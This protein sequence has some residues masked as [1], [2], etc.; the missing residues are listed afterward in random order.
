MQSDSI[1]F[2]DMMD[3]MAETGEGTRYR[4]EQMS[5]PAIAWPNKEARISCACR[6][7]RVES[8]RYSEVGCALALQAGFQ[9]F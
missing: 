3:E 4:E 6:P 7:N 2:V 1:D 9:S 5:T 8:A